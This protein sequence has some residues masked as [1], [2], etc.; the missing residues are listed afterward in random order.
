MQVGFACLHRM[1]EALG[2]QRDHG[3]PHKRR[4]RSGVFSVF[5]PATV[6]VPVF[7]AVCVSASMSLSEPTSAS[8]SRST[9]LS[10][11]LCPVCLPQSHDLGPEVHDMNAT[12]E[13]TCTHRQSFTPTM[14]IKLYGATYS[15]CT[16]RVSLVLETL[17]LQYEFA[18]IDM[19]KGE[20]KVCRGIIRSC[21]SHS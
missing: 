10:A 19:M 20:H 17:G 3:L 4:D 2:G 13:P 18:S 5:V 11:A 9:A 14:S 1:V 6:T 12:T 8:L 7:V 16:Q 21:L 15:T